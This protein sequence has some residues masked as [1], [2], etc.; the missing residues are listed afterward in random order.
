MIPRLLAAAGGSGGFIV[1]PLNYFDLTSAPHGGLN[2]WTVPSA[3]YHSGTTYVGY[4]NGGNGNIEVVTYTDAG[5]IG[6]PYVVDAAFEADAHVSPS[7]L[8]RASDGRL[9]IVYAKHNNTPINVRV[10]TNPDDAS[11]WGAATNIAAQLGGS[12]FTDYAIFEMTGYLF[13]WYRDEP[14]AGTDSRWCISYCDPTLPTSG[15]HTQQIVYRVAGSRSYVIACGDIANG[16]IQFV[17]TDTGL[18]PGVPSKVGAFYHDA[19]AGTFHKSDGTTITIPL[20]FADITQFYTSA[21]DPLSPENLTVDG[22]GYPV[23]VGEVYINGTGEWRYYYSRFNGTTW[24][25]TNVASGGTG[26]VYDPFPVYSAYGSCV[27]DGDPNV[28]YAIVP[29]SSQPELYKYTTA[30]GGSTFSSAAVTSG[31]SALR[32]QPITIRERGAVLKVVSEIGTWTSY[33]SF[34]LGLVGSGT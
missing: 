31:S 26:Y 28:M 3:I 10:S 21:T 6:G 14:S 24:A 22:S 8:R 17:A 1:P 32:I 27:D 18:A 34:S 5:T 11:A 15:W 4:V 12:R 7:L 9:I 29:V 19:G 13:L 16:R 23:H 25:N 20:A 30:D 33:T 2:P